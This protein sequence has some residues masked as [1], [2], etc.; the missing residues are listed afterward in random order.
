MLEFVIDQHDGFDLIN[1][2]PH[3]EKS[4]K[5]ETLYL[6]TETTCLYCLLAT[7]NQN[8]NIIILDLTRLGIEPTMSHIRDNHHFISS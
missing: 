5:T 4:L 3:V 6:D 1:S 7:K 2:S 8:T